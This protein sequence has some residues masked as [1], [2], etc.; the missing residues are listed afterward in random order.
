MKSM[1][2][3]E[4]KEISPEVKDAGWAN[5]SQQGKYI[6]KT[7]QCPCGKSVVV[8]EKDDFIGHRYTKTIC[9]CSECDA[10]YNFERGTATPK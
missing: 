4:L 3:K 5:Q 10:S 9:Y 2:L 8:Y 6:T 1:K 7:Y